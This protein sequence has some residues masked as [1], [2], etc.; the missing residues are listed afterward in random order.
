MP[1]YGTGTFP[2]TPTTFPSWVSDT[3]SAPL[4]NSWGAQLARREQYR[5]YFDGEVFEERVEIEYGSE[6]EAPLLYPVGVNLVKMITTTLA[7]SLFGEWSER[8]VRWE[9]SQDIEV[10]TGDHRRAAQIANQVMSGSSA[11]VGLWEIGLDAFVYGGGLIKIETNFLAPGR[12]KWTR[13]PINRFFPVYDPDDVDRLLEVYIIVPMSRDQAKAKYKYE[14][15]NDVIFRVE[16][17]TRE[18]YENTL[19]GQRIDEFS[20]RNPWGVVPFE[21][22]PSRRSTSWWGDSITQD[23]I[24]AQDELNERL[25]DIGD[26]IHYNTHPTRW[27]RNMPSNFDAASFP[28]GPNAMWDLGKGFGSD[29]MP[30][31]GILESRNPIPSGVYDYTK[32]LFNWSHQASHLPPI[33]VGIDEGGGQRSGITLEIRMMSLIRSLRRARA[34]MASGMRRAMRTSA[35]ILRQKGF[36]DIPVRAIDRLLENSIVPIFENV[37]PRDQASVVDEVQKGMSTKVPTISLE[38]A[39]KRLG[40]GT[41]ETQRI[42][43]MLSDPDLSDMFQKTAP[44]PAGVDGRAGVTE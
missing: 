31:V 9:P 13:V 33:A 44:I 36:S 26:S 23:V 14:S 37:L 24:R 27:G 28:L 5:R 7:D 10:V 1:I 41:S 19:D 2:L 21:Y 32:F 35:V 20:G 34:Y 11:D 16:H 18:I 4:A 17:W 6:E 42:L 29:S 8:I 22:I 3:V 43:D 15:G 30:E 39:V 38:T 25:A 40:Y 12:V